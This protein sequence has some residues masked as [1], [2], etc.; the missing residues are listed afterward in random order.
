MKSMKLLVLGSSGCGKSEFI[1][2]FTGKR[3]DSETMLKYGMDYVETTLNNEQDQPLNLELW[4]TY[5][6]LW[7]NKIGTYFLDQISGAIIIC[8]LNNL[9]SCNQL[10]DYISL[11]YDIKRASGIPILLIG[12]KSDL[13]RNVTKERINKCLEEHTSRIVPY[14]YTDL[15]SLES[16]ENNQ[17][18]LTY[19]NNIQKGEFII[20]KNDFISSDKNKKICNICSKSF[21]F[22]KKK[23]ECPSCHRYICKQCL[24]KSSVY[25]N[26]KQYFLCQICSK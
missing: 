8:D 6:L 18:I 14:L 5:G 25:I 23:Y 15:C 19:I 7:K 13:H 16:N 4:D 21:S 2:S 9:E 24:S 22:F 11:F 26:G 1:Y 10:I 12:N 17:V 20:P 3:T